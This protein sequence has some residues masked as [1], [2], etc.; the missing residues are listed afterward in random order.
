MKKIAVKKGDVL[1]RKGDLKSLVYLVDKGLL[2]SYTID[3]KG[4]EHIYMFGPEGWI[5]TDNC[6][7]NEP[8]DLYIDAVEDSE[9]RVVTKEEMLQAK[10]DIKALQRRL[11]VM[12]TRIVMLMS[13][14]AKERYEHFIKTYPDITQRVS[15]KMIASYL[16]ISPEALSR[17][18][19]KLSQ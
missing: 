14:N 7:V 5:V 6:G 19:H 12:Q 8:C 11:Y 1:Q 15:L 13:S 18:R 9:L 16:G 2:R 4:R 10:L 3:G 17:V